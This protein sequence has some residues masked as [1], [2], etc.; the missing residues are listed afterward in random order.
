MCVLIFFNYLLVQAPIPAPPIAQHF[1]VMPLFFFYIIYYLSGP[2]Q[3]QLT[4]LGKENL[5]YPIYYIY[6]T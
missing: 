3:G 6:H 2:A 5:G 4:P 1:L